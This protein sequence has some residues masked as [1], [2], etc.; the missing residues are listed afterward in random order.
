MT[1]SQEIKSNSIAI[2][3]PD[4]VAQWHPSK[5]GDMHPS[6]FSCGSN[7]KVW[8]QC[9]KG[10]EWETII[11]NR[12][13]RK[14]TGC[15][16][17][18]GNKASEH[19]NLAELFP[20]L[21]RDW[22]YDKN[23]NLDPKQLTPFTR[24]KV[25]WRCPKGH[26]WL[27]GIV[28]RTR[29]NSGC[30][31]C[32][33]RTAGIDN[34]FAALYPE[35]SNEWHPKKNGNLTPNDVRPGTDRKIWWLCKKG[36]TWEASLC[37]RTHNSKATGCPY[38]SGRNATIENNLAVLYPALLAEWDYEKNISLRPEELK[39][40]SNVKVWWKCIHGH[41]WQ[42]S[43]NKRTGEGTNC[44]NC[45]P[46]SSKLEIRLFCELKFLFGDEVVW[47]YKIDRIEVDLYLQK[48][49]LGLELDGFPWH[50]NKEDKDIAKTK[51]LLNRGIILFRL[52]DN[53]LPR[54]DDTDIFYGSVE[55]DWPIINRLIIHLLR[56][57]NFDSSDI[58]NLNAY[59]QEGQ[60]QNIN[61]YSLS[62]HHL[63]QNIPLR[64]STN[65]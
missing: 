29:Q 14:N 24:Q 42:T 46:Q 32:S 59:V 60:I 44:P 31:Y 55:D 1:Q 64:V 28:Y 10:H 8:W 43:L 19:Y 58:V 20:E 65:I 53:K 34:S 33:G 25:W 36:H 51:E 48:Y 22:C 5:N 38:C 40:G 54:I 2:K 47:R 21:L 30:P 27:T 37:Q 49:S 62:C 3:R 57:A 12:T 13:G 61:E 23:S 50:L 45:A 26:E 7:L 16:Y 52:R 4:L 56:H 17:C 11:A 39:P 6:Q 63:H 9:E 41:E 15:P 35:L 18:S